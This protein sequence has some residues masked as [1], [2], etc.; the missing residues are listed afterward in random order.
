MPK[1]GTKFNAG[2]LIVLRGDLKG[3]GSLIWEIEF[4]HDDHTHPEDTFFGDTAILKVPDS[5]HAFHGETGFKLNLYAERNGIRTAPTVVNI[6]P[7]KVDMSIVS[8]VPGLEVYGKAQST[9]G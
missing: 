7:R 6:Y 1:E 8:N 3:S 9:P 2:E 5:G 4:A